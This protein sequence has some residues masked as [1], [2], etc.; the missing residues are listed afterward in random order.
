MINANAVLEFTSQKI[1]PIRGGTKQISEMEM[2]RNMND[3]QKKQVKQR[4]W[5]KIIKDLEKNPQHLMEIIPTPKNK[6]PYNDTL[7]TSNFE[8][9]KRGG[10]SLLST[11][12]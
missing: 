2:T 6:L 9:K 3:K 10:G 4:K 11:L 12:Q 1:S 7:H 5:G 8:S